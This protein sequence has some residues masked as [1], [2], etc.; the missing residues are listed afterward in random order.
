MVPAIVHDILAQDT[1]ASV[2]FDVVC[3]KSDLL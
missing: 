2:A 1:A 3:G